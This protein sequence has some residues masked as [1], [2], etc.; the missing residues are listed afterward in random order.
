MKL[1]IFVS[2]K[3]I[4]DIFILSDNFDYTSITMIT[5]LVN[6]VLISTAQ[7]KNIKHKM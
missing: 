7:G 3:Y 6:T 1:F 5:M 2:D 4:F